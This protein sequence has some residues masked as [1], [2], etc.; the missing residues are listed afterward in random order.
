MH[1]HDM[2]YWLG[3]VAAVSMTLASQA[4][5]LPEPIRHYVTIAGLI[6]TVITSYKITPTG[7]VKQ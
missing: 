4:E 6:A 2:K 5:L 1:P 3:L 7:S